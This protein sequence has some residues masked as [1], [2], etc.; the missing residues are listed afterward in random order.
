MK[1]I[2]SRSLS[3]ILILFVL[4][5]FPGC[6]DTN[7]K[8]S[9]PAVGANNIQS[10]VPSVPDSKS[11]ADVKTENVPTGDVAVS[12]DGKVLKKSDLDNNVKE[13]FNLIKDKIPSDK[14]KEFKENIRKQ[15]IDLFIAR[16]LLSNE[17]EKRKIEASNQEVTA[18]MD[19]IKASLPPNKKIDDFLKE[20]KI[21]QQDIILAVK[22]EKFRN[23]EADQKVK[24][25]QKEINKFYNDN[26]EKLF[27]ES[28]S[29]HVRHIL[30][31]V[32]KND[33]DKVKA[34]K[35]EKIENLRRQLLNGG[36]FGE[37]ARKNSDCPS[38]EVGGDLNYI[39]KGQMTKEFEN[40]AFSQEKNAIGPV[41]KTEFG[42]HI[43][44]VLDHKPAKKV[45]LEEAKGKISSYLEQR[46]KMEA[47]NDILKKLKEN[48]KIIVY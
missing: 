28:E 12:V 7:K 5:I 36:D 27:V 9:V 32:G 43:V 35:K 40:A 31:A 33:S 25:T 4:I 3:V 21:T 13:K 18:A 17:V 26:R 24:P 34:E 16:T 45:T 46:K 39:R 2:I 30:V 1:T 6:K 14:Q 37:L 41:I 44:Q 47:F 38:K 11:V 48:A 29:V 42:Y 22:I 8:E 19:S 15:L 20:N 23:M 10:S